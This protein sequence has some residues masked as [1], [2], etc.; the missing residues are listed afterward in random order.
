[1]R[2]AG[3]PGL[4][5]TPGLVQAGR[6]GR[7]A[8]LAEARQLGFT[9]VTDHG[10]ERA[11]AYE[12]LSP[13][14]EE[15]LTVM[16]PTV[17]PPDW[18]LY[19]PGG[20]PRPLSQEAARRLQEIARDALQAH[21]AHAFGAA[22]HEHDL[23][24]PG[25]LSPLPAAL[26]ALRLLLDARVRPSL[27]LAPPPPVPAPAPAALG[28]RGRLSRA[29]ERATGA[30]ARHA[31]HP[32]GERVRVGRREI[33]LE[34]LGPRSPRAIVLCSHAGR[35]GGRRLG[36]APVG[37]D[38]EDL[39]R[40]EL[41]LFVYDRAGTGDSPADGPLTPGNP[42]HTEDWRAALA[43]ARS[44]GLPV[45]ALTWSSGVIPVL[46]AT[47]AGARPDALIDAEGPADRWSLVPPEGNELSRRDPWAEAL[48]EGLEPAR[49]L[50]AL[51][52]PYAR[53]QAEQDHV[54]GPMHEHAR[55]MLA[56]ARGA[57]LPTLDPG[58]LP[59]RLRD[60]PERALQ[61]LTWALAQVQRS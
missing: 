15:G 45:L 23:C 54:H 46:R 53:L 30:L 61:A 16:A 55:R 6:A 57:G 49:L 27:E 26:D 43:R 40:A 39:A 14:V 35:E 51:G 21:G 60:H 59:G 11:W 48:W 34:R 24:A 33:V 31:P 8:L 56:A 58:L 41:G 19:P 25:S 36:L 38:V 2:A 10:P 47:A 13:R 9:L 52:A 29:L 1:M 7:R 18:G 17:R 22:L 50:P 44:E 37:L 20:P 32:G 12:G 5:A 42:A 4:V 3:V 28:L